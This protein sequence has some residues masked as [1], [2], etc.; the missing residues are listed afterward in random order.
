MTRRLTLFHVIA[1]AGLALAGSAAIATAVDVSP[2]EISWQMVGTDVVRFQLHFHNANPVEPTLGV[3]GAMH[4]QEFGAFLPDYGL[5]GTFVIPPMEP[6]S[7]FDVF[8]D[9][10][11]SALPPS[12]GGGGGGGG[13]RAALLDPCPP[14]IWVGNVD[15]NWFGPGGVGQVNKHYGD[16]GV[17]AGGPPSCLHVITMCP[18]NLTWAFVMNCPGWTVT[19]LNEDYSPAPALLPPNWT[20]WV[21][22]SANASVLMGSQCCFNLNLVCA[23]VTATIDVCAFAC[24]CPVKVEQGTWGRIKSMYR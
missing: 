3:Q 11:L 1:F 5:I 6:E 20:G 14:P 19:L 12:Q 10:P 24:G 16:I 21:C 9:V 13:L 2:P 4:S 18:G 7:F 17:C 8:F 15:V 23:G 22:V